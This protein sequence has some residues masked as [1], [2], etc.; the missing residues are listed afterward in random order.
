M[1]VITIKTQKEFDKL[2]DKFDEYMVIE[3]KSSENIVICIKRAWENSSVIA[4]EN[5]SVIARENSS[6]EARGN[7]SVEA[8]ENSSVIARENSSVI[9]W[10]NSS[11]IAR[12]NSSVEAC[13]NSSVEARDN[14]SVMAWENSS[15]IARENSSV[16]ARDNSSVEARENSSVI[17]LATSC[18]HLLSPSAQVVLF[19]FAVAFQMVEAVIKKK[20]KTATII[21]PEYKKGVGGWVEKNC[22]EVKA[23]IILF[24]RVS[25]DFKTQEGTKNET[26]WKIG[27][28]VTHPSWKPQEDECGEGK[29]HACSRPYFC[30]EFRENPKDKYI[31]IEI[32]KKDLYAWPNPEY[33]HKIAFKAGKV[34]F[35]VD[36]LGKKK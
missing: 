3:I 9:A 17:A 30:D 29:F 36:R 26:N 20:S 23:K 15:V 22:V 14:S 5:S 21:I 4:R 10:E 31:A 1:K 8:R 24:K 12:E 27:D 6:V 18:V 32:A 28:V 13:D 7:S 19:G 35:E 34:L 2:P 11:V 16:E 33:P 25:E